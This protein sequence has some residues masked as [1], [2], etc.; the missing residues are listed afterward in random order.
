M[1]FLCGR[2]GIVSIIEMISLV[3]RYAYVRPLSL[4]GLP[5]ALG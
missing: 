5:L 1:H 3:D 4:G 2:G